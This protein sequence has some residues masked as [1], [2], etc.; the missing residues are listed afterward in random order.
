MIHQQEPQ[1][2][3]SNGGWR[4]EELTPGTWRGRGPCRSRLGPPGRSF[5][6][7]PESPPLLPPPPRP[8]HKTAVKVWWVFQIWAA[9]NCEFEPRLTEKHIVNFLFG[10]W[11]K[12]IG[13]SSPHECPLV[14][15]CWLNG[16]WIQVWN[17]ETSS[18]SHV[19][20]Q[21]L[22]SYTFSFPLRIEAKG[23]LLQIVKQDLLTV[24]FWAELRNW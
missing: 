15:R 17:I 11:C 18:E 2:G 22:R 4:V 13:A 24:K 19:L 14:A 12:T 20:H 9:G 10:C 21:T 5:R 6:S 7:R 8:E 23:H 3:G 16:L 1:T